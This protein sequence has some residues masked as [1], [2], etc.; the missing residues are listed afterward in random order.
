MTKEEMQ[1]RLDQQAEQIEN[2]KKQ[3]LKL[4]QDTESAFKETPLYKSLQAEINT[5]SKDRDFWQNA[6]KF[7]QDS[8]A[9][10]TA[11]NS[12]Y[13]SKKIMQLQ[14]DNRNFLQNQD[15][16]YWIGMTETADSEQLRRLSEENDSLKASLA[17]AEKRLE[18]SKKHNSLLQAQLTSVLY[19]LHP[20]DVPQEAL[21]ELRTMTKEPVIGRPKESTAFDEQKARKL[22]KE[23][24]SIRVI[25]DE[26]G[27]SVGKTQSVV[28]SV[29]Q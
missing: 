20:E 8:A 16:S 23:G 18:L 10:L 27:W 17:K 13:F 29:K 2:L 28:K 7:A 14:Q 9:K 25:A 22:R 19:E 24:K 1:Q 12:K 6:A 5:V 3:M 21:Q 26:M 11:R 15:V 4:Q